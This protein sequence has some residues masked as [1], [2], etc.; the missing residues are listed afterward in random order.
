[1]PVKRHW[2]IHSQA[3]MGLLKSD[4]EG[5]NIFENDIIWEGEEGAGMSHINLLLFLLLLFSC[6]FLRIKSTTT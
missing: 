6:L 1:M 2:H 4:V 3:Q 5:K